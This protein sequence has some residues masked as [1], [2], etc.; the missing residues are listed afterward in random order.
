M[1]EF[2]LE[3][4]NE[5]VLPK[6]YQKRREEDVTL[7]IEPDLCEGCGEWKHVVVF[8]RPESL[9][10]HWRRKRYQKKYEKPRL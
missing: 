7:S 6:R 4:F 10:H 2:C 9:W 8:D 5:Q 1:A 3:C